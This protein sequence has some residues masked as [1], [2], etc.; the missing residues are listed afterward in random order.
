[1]QAIDNRAAIEA[2]SRTFWQN[3]TT[4]RLAPVVAQLR[5]A[6]AGWRQLTEGAYG[7]VAHPH[8][9][10]LIDARKARGDKLF[11]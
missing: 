11:A 10:A 7:S 5:S 6:R 1:M 2:R 3:E 9:T 8:Y 4:A